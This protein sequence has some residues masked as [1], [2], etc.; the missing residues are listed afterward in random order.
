MSA[1][2]VPLAFRRMQA[3][4]TAAGLLDMSGDGPPRVTDAGDAW[5]DE[6][7]A[8]LKAGRKPPAVPP[9]T[10]IKRQA[11]PTAPAGPI[12]DQESANDRSVPARAA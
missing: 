4:L 9:A 5:T 11:I 7:I 10:K 6:L 3:R 8:A 2:I 12:R 1:A